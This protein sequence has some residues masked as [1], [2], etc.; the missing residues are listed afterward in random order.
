MGVPSGG[1]S[2][3]YP[4]ALDLAI[5]HEDDAVHSL[6]DQLAARVVEDLPRNRVQVETGLEA[7][8]RAELE[9]Q[10]I[11]E[12]RAVRFG[13]QRDQLALVAR[14][15]LVVDELQIRRLP[16]QAGA[17]VDELAV[18]LPGGPRPA[19]GLQ[20]PDRREPKPYFALAQPTG[21]RS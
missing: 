11:E 1:K 18:D 19:L 20:K 3:T 4:H 12:Q 16:A 15:R 7:A 14:V 10:E 21:N 2:P 5:G 8:H 6:E 9:R 17:V 13:R